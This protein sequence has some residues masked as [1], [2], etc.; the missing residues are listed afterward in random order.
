MKS[1]ELRASIRRRAARARPGDKFL[2]AQANGIIAVGFLHAG[3]V[4]LKRLHVLVFTEHG[5]RRMR[6]GGVTAYPT[7]EWTV[8]QARPPRPGHPPADLSQER[9]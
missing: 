4:L 7:G 5:T 6:L 1:C 9:I 2:H 3:T 8:Q